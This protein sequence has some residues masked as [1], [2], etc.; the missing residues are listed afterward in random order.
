MNVFSPFPRKGLLGDEGSQGLPGFPGLQGMMGK[1]GEGGLPGREGERGMI[2]LPGSQGPE[3]NEGAPGYS[4]T[5]GAVGRQGSPGSPGAPGAPAPPAPGPRDR[6]FHFSRHSQSEMI[7]TC[8]RNTVKMW[9]GFSLLHIMGN[10]KPYGQDLGAAGSCVQKFSTMPFMFCNINNVCDYANRNDYSYWLSTMEPMPMSMTPIPAPEVGRYISR[11]SVCEA[12]TRAIAVHSQSMAIPECP[13]GWEELWIGYSFLMHR[14]AGAGGG[15]QSLVS[16]GSCL[17]EFR[18]RPFI[19][20]RG[21]GTCNYFSTA[22]SYWLAT[23]KDYEMFRKPSQQTL[24]ADHTSR[25]SRCAVCLRRRVTEDPYGRSLKPF[26]SNGRKE[27]AGNIR[28]QPRYP[29]YQPQV[30]P[31][32]GRVRNPNRRGPYN[33]RRRGPAP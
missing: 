29:T 16:P 14:D 33:F 11:C 2:G 4:G 13:G 7:P 8:P 12:P 30:Q 25:I 31:P 20:C 10:G 18:A 19:E 17:E 24:K 26:T 28:Y 32:P 27:S 5:R 22:T 23:I 1:P 3:G 21:L 15:G 9:D 6:G